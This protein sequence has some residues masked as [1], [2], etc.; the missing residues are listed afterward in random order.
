MEK[1]IVRV[2]NIECGSDELFL[3]SGP[4]VIEEEKIMMETAEK[5]KGISERLK[6]KIIYKSSFQK[7]NRSSLK[8]YT[9]P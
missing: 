9:G 2:G 3:I 4:C 5:L 8:Y 1:K 7:D 6:I